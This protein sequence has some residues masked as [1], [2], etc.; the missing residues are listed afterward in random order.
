MKR[1]PIDPA[2]SPLQLLNQMHDHIV[3][4]E[5]LHNPYARRG[6]IA[7][8]F[9]LLLNSTSYSS[10]QLARIIGVAPQTVNRWKAGKTQ[11]RLG[12]IKKLQEAI[13]RANGPRDTPSPRPDPARLGTSTLG[14]RSVEEILTLE[15]GAQDV[16]IVKNGVLREAVPGFVGD[17]VLRGLKRGTNFHYVFASES[18][19]EV[20][21][22]RHFSE[23]IQRETFTGCLTGHSVRDTHTAYKLHLSLAPGAWVAIRY[24]SEQSEQLR[25]QFDVFMAL[26]VRQY[27]D[28]NRTIIENED[29]QAHWFELPSQQAWHLLQTFKQCTE[30]RPSPIEDIDS[31]VQLLRL[32]SSVV[33]VDHSG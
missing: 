33:T 18:A 15:A 1:K 30:E 5:L 28:S 11:P 16:W 27:I 14:V 25:R 10:P 19:A 23:W 24:S 32:H 31:Q 6:Q 4:S 21:F 7:E 22:Q 9:S 13:M 20:S 12:Q 17:M 8:L 3:A 2:G 26:P 29:G